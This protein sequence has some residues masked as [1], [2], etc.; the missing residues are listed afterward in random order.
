MSKR[1]YD[2]EVIKVAMAKHTAGLK[3]SSMLAQELGI[4]KSTFT[5]WV[6]AYERN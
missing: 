6:L 5:M 2:V 1:K 3:S 4:S